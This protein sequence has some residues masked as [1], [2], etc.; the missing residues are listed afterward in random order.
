MLLSCKIK[1][2]CTIRFEPHPEPTSNISQLDNLGKHLAALPMLIFATILHV[3]AIV[4][5]CGRAAERPP[6]EAKCGGWRD[7]TILPFHW[8]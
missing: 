1:A 6:D 2:T 8:A 7:S 4:E 3:Q 5:G